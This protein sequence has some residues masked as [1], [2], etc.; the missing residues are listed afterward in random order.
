MPDPSLVRI[1]IRKKSTDPALGKTPGTKKKQKKDPS[2][3]SGH[4][5]G[6]IPGD[7]KATYSVCTPTI[8]LSLKC[9]IG[10][11]GEFSYGSHPAR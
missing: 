8:D 6:R 1:T 7:P 4:H 3:L 11:Q 10:G 5:L 2:D 9:D